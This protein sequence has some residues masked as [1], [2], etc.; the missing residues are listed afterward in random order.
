MLK[1]ILEKWDSLSPEIRRRLEFLRI[2]KL[3]LSQ[4]FLE[5]AGNVLK[6]DGRFFYKRSP[7]GELGEI[8]I[9]GKFSQVEKLQSGFTG[10]PHHETILQLKFLA[11]R[12]QENRTLLFTGDSFHK[13]PHDSFLSQISYLIEAQEKVSSRLWRN[14][15]SRVMGYY[16]PKKGFPAGISGTE[17]E[18]ISSLYSLVNAP[19]KSRQSLIMKLERGEMEALRFHSKSIMVRALKKALDDMSSYYPLTCL[20]MESN[21]KEAVKALHFMN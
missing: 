19:E 21:H 12:T 2:S 14:T 10:F 3:S 15:I 4:V 7:L 20:W 1:I 9:D 13:T 17:Y 8:S 6:P 16:S 5:H 18:I 11:P